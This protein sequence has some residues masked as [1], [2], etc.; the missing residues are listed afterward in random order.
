VGAVQSAG[1][2]VSHREIT[3]AL[4]AIRHR[5]PDDQGIWHEGPVIFG[6]RRLSIVDLS[7]A[8]HQPMVSAAA[9]YVITFN[10]EIY[11]HAALRAELEADGPRQWRGSSDTEVL[12][13]LIAERGIEAALAKADGMFAFALWDRYD[14]RLLLARDRFGEKPLYYAQRNGGF[15]FASE[16]GALEQISALNLNVSPESAAQYFL[17]G[18]VPAPLSLYDR[19]AKLPPGCLLHWRLGE[20]PRVKTYWAA[21]EMMRDAALAGSPPTEMGAA[22]EQLDE[23]IQRAVAERMVADVPVG[24][25]LSGG[26]DSSLIAAV[27]QRSAG[28]PITTLT[29]GFEDP[30]FNEA[31]HA[32]A[33]AN[34]LGTK[35]IEEIANADQALA[36]VARLGRMYDEPLADP[37]QIPTFLVCEM[38][39]RHVT[40]ALS[41]DGGDEVFAG[42]RRHFATPQ[43]WRRLKQVPMRGAARCVIERTPL[44][45]LDSSLGFL[46]DFSDRYGTGGS[47]GRTLK[48]VAPWLEA[49]SLLDLHEHSLEKWPRGDGMVPGVNAVWDAPDY[50]PPSAVDQLCLHDMRHYLPGDILHK[51]DRAAMAV[52]LETRIPYLDPDVVR[53]SMSLPEKLR[54]NGATGKLVLRETLKRYMP[55]RLFD[56]QKTGFAPPLEAWLLGP[57][58]AWAEDLLSPSRLGRHGLLDVNRVRQFWEQYVQGGTMQDQRAW[59]V[60]Q[61]QSWMAARNG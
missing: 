48:R 30:R 59:S 31:D 54:L 21:D 24:V 44:A 55:E 4:D 39:R 37:S 25:F 49:N 16:L 32:R 6:H 17:R 15:V 41:G 45:V 40:V 20:S 8:G 42:Y 23:L 47:V 51:V 56:R 53:F 12:L 26:V 52:S 50:T 2:E 1:L 29:L 61:F 3:N 34:Y 28:R 43:L 19:V 35:H 36:V 22:V 13:E 14:K 46:K 27:M 33:I 5:G 18:Y 60:L 10:G 57:L 7:P 11:N 9:R 58:R 38:A